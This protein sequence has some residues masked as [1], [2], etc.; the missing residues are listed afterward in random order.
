MIE[1]G[2]RVFASDRRTTTVV[3]KMESIFEETLYGIA[4][5]DFDGKTVSILW[6]LGSELNVIESNPKK[7]ETDPP[8]ATG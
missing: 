3:A 2:S 4:G 5:D 8:S 7:K 1:L 6:Y